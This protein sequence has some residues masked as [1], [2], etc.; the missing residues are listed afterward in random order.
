MKSQIML[1]VLAVFGIALLLSQQY[2]NLAY[3]V[4]TV[5]VVFPSGTTTNDVAYIHIAEGAGT[6]AFATIVGANGGQA[7]AWTKNTSDNISNNVTLTGSTSAFAVEY[8]PVLGQ[9]FV[10]TNDKYYKLSQALAIAGQFAT[11]QA[12]TTRDLIYEP[13]TQ[14]MYFCFTDGYGTI[15]TN[16]LVPTVLYT[17]AGLNAVQGCALDYS[18]GAMYLTGSSV[19]GS[20]DI[21]RVSLA[22]HT[23]TNSHS[24]A[25]FYGGVCVDTENNLIWAVESSMAR[26]AKYNGTLTLITTVTV[27]TT[28]RNCSISDDT[29]ARRLYVANEGTD[30][31]SI[32]DIDA[33]AVIN[34]QSVCDTTI[35]RLL[36]TAR[37]FNTT[38]TFVTCNSNTN[39]VVVDDTV[40]PSP[41]EEPEP[42]GNAVNGRCGNGTVLDCI[43]DRSVGLAI[44]G[45][46]D[47]TTVSGDL[48][49]GIGFN[50]TCT[51][52]AKD[53][54]TGL[55]LML[56]TGTFF[57]GIIIASVATANTRF[58]AGISYT[59]I[60][61]ELWLFLVVGVV[62]FSWYMQW[63]PDIVFYGMIVGLAGLFAFGLYKHV[64]GG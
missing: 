33:N 23:I 55:L 35:T 9:S 5:S 25:N 16:T 61:K 36:D 43:G 4:S 38:R 13:T 19:G 50:V 15:N 54:G 10:S 30:T 20:F 41:D 17:D 6:N 64:R 1:T 52:D 46:S 56:I 34:T 53:N 31:I 37:F 44:T 39:T 28:P 8:H 7:Y 49:C 60:P 62:A 40:S 45:G 57:S 47:I 48:F 29:G 3:A 63:I 51:G 26:V 12:S 32:I 11:G 58:G 21:I 59:E 24:I 42:N 2:V 18:A 14:T 22:T 27:G